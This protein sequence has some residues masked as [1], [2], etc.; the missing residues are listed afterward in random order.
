MICRVSVVKTDITNLIKYSA[1]VFVI[2]LLVRHTAVVS[3]NELVLI[4]LSGL[5]HRLHAL[6]QPEDAPFI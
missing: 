1:Y 3:V 6:L 5:L 4:M 2:A